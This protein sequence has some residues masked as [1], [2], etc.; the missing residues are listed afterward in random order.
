[1]SY[2]K[3]AVISGHSG[4]HTCEMA[5]KFNDNFDLIEAWLK[6]PPYLQ[7]ERESVAV[8]LDLA[9]IAA[10]TPI[11]LEVDVSSCSKH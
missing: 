6:L 3:Q 11:V 4:L 10:V 5:L 7:G 1:M 8:Q 2:V 9:L